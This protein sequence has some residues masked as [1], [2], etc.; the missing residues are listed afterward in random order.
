MV[1]DKLE[2]DYE[3]QMVIDRTVASLNNNPPDLNKLKRIEKFI[4]K[5]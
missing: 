4:K 1:D 2:Y 3:R 5:R